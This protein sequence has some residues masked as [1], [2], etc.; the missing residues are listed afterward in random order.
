MDGVNYSHFTRPFYKAL[1]RF[2]SYHEKLL[3]WD[4]SYFF[5]GPF[6][7]LFTFKLLQLSHFLNKIDKTTFF[8]KCSLVSQNSHWYGN[9]GRNNGSL[10]IIKITFYPVM[11]FFF[12]FFLKNVK[13][14]ALSFLLLKNIGK[15]FWV[16]KVLSK[17]GHSSQM[18]GSS[19]LLFSFT[20]S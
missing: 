15:D 2:Y 11:F 1:T 13:D 4:S 16:T 5:H 6:Y 14:K 18:H 10:K 19:N 8:R 20:D 12:F 9:D 7:L 3:P 17:A